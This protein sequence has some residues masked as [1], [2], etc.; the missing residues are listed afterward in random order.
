MKQLIALEELAMLL[1]SMYVFSGLSYAWWVYPALILAPDIS[2]AGYAVGNKA[3]AWVYNL[4]HHKAIAI[5]V[6]VAG[7]YTANEPLQLAGVILFG[8]ASMDRMLGYGL[9]TYDG[10]TFTH[11]G[12]ISRQQ[13]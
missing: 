1:L 13:P 8:H 4:F 5:A 9:K 2:M 6:Y 3:G 12:A 11:L 10:F 7:L